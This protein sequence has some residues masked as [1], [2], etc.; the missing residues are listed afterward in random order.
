MS[1][2]QDDTLRELKRIEEDTHLLQDLSSQLE[3]LEQKIETLSLAT[4]TE[5]SMNA[6]GIQEI[7][8]KISTLSALIDK[9]EVEISHLNSRI[10]D[11]ESL[12]F[13]HRSRD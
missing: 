11:I 10:D 4:R 1:N 3:K 5:A 7:S 2:H 8:T 12:R 9:I 6:E 13:K